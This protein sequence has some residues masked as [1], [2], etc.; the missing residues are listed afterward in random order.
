VVELPYGNF[1]YGYRESMT[2]RQ[3][4]TAVIKDKHGR[5]LSI[6]QNSSITTASVYD[7]KGRVL[8]IAQN[9]FTKT[10]P[11]QAEF[12]IKVNLPHACYLHAEVSAIIKALKKG[13]PY[14]IKIE[15]YYKNGDQ[16]LAKPCPICELAIKAANIKKVYFTSTE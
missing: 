11:K 14:K 10:H 2:K 7:K 1:Y 5:V 8:S 12:A 3:V 4:I 16:A 9:S 15:R 6:G 13:I